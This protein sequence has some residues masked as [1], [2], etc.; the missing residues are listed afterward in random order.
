MREQWP[1]T[2]VIQAVKAAV[3]AVIAWL[4]AAEWWGLPQPF[5]APY[6][7]VFLIEATVY[8]ALW[9][10]LQQIGAVVLGVVLAA[11]AIQ[12]LPWQAVALGLVVFTGLLLGRWRGF[13][14]SGVWVGVT[15]LLLV[16]YGTAENSML[17]LD[18]VGET[19]L[20]AAIG[21]AMNAL[22]FPPVYTRGTEAATRAV[23]AELADVLCDIAATLREPSVPDSSP[24]WVARARNTEQLLRRAEEAS[25]WGTESVR[26][27][28]RS[29]VGDRGAHVARW[30]AL[31][32]QLRAAW[33][34]VRE[35]T[36]ALDHAVREH[37]AYRY[38]SQEV[39]ERLAALLDATA[40]LSRARADGEELAPIV[41]EG[42]EAM[43][44]LE[45]DLVSSQGVDL[46]VGLAGVLLP[47]KKAF[48]QFAA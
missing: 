11:V 47:A 10:A 32:V 19:V 28:P 30:H 27:N 5:L 12:V 14:S 2:A 37:D 29:K 8:R 4:I 41:E 36:E 34:H 13:G 9:S 23:A 38:P 3:A 45:R 40:R 46:T 17:M 26:F 31:M 16:S 44:A 39:R 21:V 6:A 18:R 42:R 1:R 15:A 22:V 43:D 33:P 48:E 20:G 24:H 35:L 7:A 25:G